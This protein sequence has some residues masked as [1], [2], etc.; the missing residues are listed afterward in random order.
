[1]TTEIALSRGYVTVIDDAD[2]A[3]TAGYNWTAAVASDRR[4][5]YAVVTISKRALYLHKMLAPQWA[6]VDHADGDGLNNCRYNLR[7]GTGFRNN[8]NK[9]MLSSNTS[10]YK[11]VSWNKQKKRW[12]AGIRVE[13]KSVFLGYFGTPEEAAA[14]YDAAAIDL[15]GE[16][17]KT[18]AML[19]ASL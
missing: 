7:D 19:L 9:A 3:A 18:N 1:V 12:V 11:G 4:T 10:G 6:I 8:A 2:V 5:V 14:A 16:Y 15:F 13:G 17:A